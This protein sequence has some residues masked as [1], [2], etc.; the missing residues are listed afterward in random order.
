[1]NKRGPHL[2]PLKHPWDLSLQL[3]PQFQGVAVA[4]VPP[5]EIHLLLQLLRVERLR[6]V[7]EGEG[8]K[9]L[10]SP[11]RLSCCVRR[12]GQLA[13]QSLFWG[14]S[15]QQVL[16]WNPNLETYCGSSLFPSSM[17]CK[18]ILHMKKKK[19]N[20]KMHFGWVC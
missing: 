7:V 8:D 3:L 18:C 15:P 1:M 19:K 4:V 12:T 9:A 5:Y 17:L 6:K 2:N 10:T 13:S 16:T 14:I 11:F 20:D